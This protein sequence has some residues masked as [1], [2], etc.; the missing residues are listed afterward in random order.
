MLDDGLVLGPITGTYC[1]LFQN[2]ISNIP[3][4]TPSLF[5]QTRRITRHKVSVTRYKSVIKN[6]AMTGRQPV[7]FTVKY[8]AVGCQFFY[9]YFYRLPLRAFT[10]RIFFEIKIW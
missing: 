5:N 9:R 4:F 8:L 1:G 2:E 6:T 10:C 7:D 3:T